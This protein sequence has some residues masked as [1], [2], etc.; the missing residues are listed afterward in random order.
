VPIIKPVS[1]SS[2]DRF[3]KEAMTEYI[4]FST[5]ALEALFKSHSRRVREKLEDWDKIYRGIPKEKERDFPWPKASNVVVQIVGQHVDTLTARV[6]GSIYELDPL[7]PIKAC[8]TWAI[9][10][11]VEDMRAGVEEFLHNNALDPSELDLYRIHQLWYA[12]AIKYGWKGVKVIQDL[13]VE[14]SITGSSN[15][16]IS[17]EVF[18]GPRVDNVNYEDLLVNNNYKTL[19]DQPVIAERMYYTAQD[20]KIRKYQK[21]FLE[22]AVDKV[23]R[24]T[25]DDNGSNDVQ[26]RN[27][28]EAGLQNAGTTKAFDRWHI[29]E[30]WVKFF[31]SGKM[32]STVCYI[33]QTTGTFMGGYFNYLPNNTIPYIGARL[34]YRSSDFYGQ[35]FCELLEHAQTEAT[36][37]HNRR[38]DNATVANLNM[39]RVSPKAVRLGTNIKLQPLSVLRADKDE[40][41][42][43]DMG[44]NY[45]STANDEEL[46]L[47]EAADRSGTQPAV[48]GSGS[49]SVNAKK[50]IYSSQGT[51]AT[52]IDGNRRVNLD[53]MDMR[54]AHTKLGKMLLDF[55]SYF[56]VP[57]QKLAPYGTQGEHIAEALEK[58]KSGKFKISVRSTTAS[59]NREVDRQN[60]VFLSQVFNR[61]FMAMGQFLQS[62]LTPQTPAP[63]RDYLLNIA[64][65]SQ[66]LMTK[67]AKS[68]GYENASSFLPTPKI[69]EQLEEQ[70]RQQEAAAAKQK[71]LTQG[72]TDGLDKNTSGESGTSVEFGSEQPVQNVPS[73][74]TGDTSTQP[75]STVESFKSGSGTI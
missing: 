72:G 33:H 24:T 39:F 26:R 23:L 58:Y 75:G 43:L 2:A 66:T 17:I 63:M 57:N 29:Y 67:I 12:D 55:Y 13:Q 37:I 25:P 42:A 64:S 60:D 61:H 31:H 8:G 28:S 70:Q 71:E 74:S 50:G 40:I 68:F 49:G 9:T 6:L 16:D 32:Y 35:G 45:P 7:W 3:N 52:M 20:L 69:I 21:K 11:K 65:A 5:E 22:D 38:N 19:E 47:K 41:E 30:C 1:L 15:T 51:M 53:T 54:Y 18:N 48:A 59:V 73:V 44:R 27:D 10:D 46:I 36:A 56:G 62:I 14:Q 4:G 34:G